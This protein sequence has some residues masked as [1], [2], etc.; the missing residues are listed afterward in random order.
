MEISLRPAAAEDEPFIRAL[1]EEVVAD[2]LGARG[3]P[4]PVRLPLLDMQ[5]RARRQG[6]QAAFPAALQ[7]IIL[8]EEQAAG[9]MVV[10]PGTDEIRLVDIAVKP[11]F[12]GNGLAAS[13]IR[14]LQAEAARA[15]LPLRLSVARSS[16]AVDLYRRLGFEIS[17][18]D[19]M[20]YAMQWSA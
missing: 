5:Y 13:C 7:Q 10:A 6:L 18:G 3:W 12:R 4:E 15:A 1:I 14:D 17:G 9:W 19:E 8:R 16:R 20:R 11:V 2:D